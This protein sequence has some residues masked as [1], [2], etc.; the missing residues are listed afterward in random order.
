MPAALGAGLTAGLAKKAEERPGSA[1][2][3]LGG[4]LELHRRGANSINVR[5]LCN[6]GEVMCF[7]E[8]R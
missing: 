5:D 7:D 6:A 2:E 4:A 1:R 8:P 3:M